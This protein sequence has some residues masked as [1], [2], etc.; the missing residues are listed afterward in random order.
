M[1]ETIL[2]S[3]EPVGIRKKEDQVPQMQEFQGPAADHIL[4]GHHLKE[5]L[6][7]VPSAFPGRRR[8][9]RVRPIGSIDKPTIIR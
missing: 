9:D 8:G 6:N 2:S 5:E 3:H 4:S 1:Q 7:L